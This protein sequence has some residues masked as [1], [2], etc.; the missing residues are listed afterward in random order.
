[1]SGTSPAQDWALT[2]VRDAEAFLATM[3]KAR[4]R[5]LTVMRQY[6]RFARPGK[7]VL[8]DP[9]RGVKA[10]GLS[11]FSGTTVAHV[12]VTR[13]TKTGRA[14]ASTAYV[15]HLLDPCGIHPEPSGALDSPTW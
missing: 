12:I 3:S 11:G 9:V 10:K 14:P 13:I 5:S 6:F 1:M 15:S 7:I 2:D 8:I 4:Q